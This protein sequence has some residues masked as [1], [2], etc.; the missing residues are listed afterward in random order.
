M[1]E[2]PKEEKVESFTLHPCEGLTLAEGQGLTLVKIE[3]APK[4]KVKSPKGFT[5]KEIMSR[6]EA[7]LAKVRGG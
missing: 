4:R 7:H 3:E 5:A 1:T 6:Y 2:E